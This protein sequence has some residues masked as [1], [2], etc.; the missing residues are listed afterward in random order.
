MAWK[1]FPEETFTFS[2]G[3]GLSGVEFGANDLV[4]V[5]APGPWIGSRVKPPGGSPVKKLCTVLV[6]IFNT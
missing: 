5:V 1:M 2:V 4:A 3:A 6:A